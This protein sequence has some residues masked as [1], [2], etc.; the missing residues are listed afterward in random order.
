MKKYGD[1]NEL[2]DHIKSLTGCYWDEDFWLEYRA[3]ERAIDAAPE[4]DLVPRA[5]IKEIFAAFEK[6]MQDNLHHLVCIGNDVQDYYDVD[7]YDAFWELRKK[8]VKTKNLYPNQE[9]GECPVW[10]NMDEPEG[11]SRNEAVNKFCSK[12][13]LYKEAEEYYKN[14]GYQNN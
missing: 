6:I 13:K 10:L 3:V 2:K 5:V 7:L 8:Y 12:C 9:C 1:L 4:E 11:I 14:S